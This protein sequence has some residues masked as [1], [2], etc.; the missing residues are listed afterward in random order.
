VR[1]A[2]LGTGSAF[3][4]ERYNG[5]VVVD[6]RL[7]L[8]AGA[9]LLPHMA[10]LGIDPGGIEALFLT[11]LH[12][13][14]IL[15]L[16]PY[17]LHRVFLGASGP[18]RV[19]GAKGVEEH[20]EKLFELSWH[21]EWAHFRERARLEYDE[22][23]QQGEV[24]GVAYET[25]GLKHGETPA[26]GYRLRV[27]GRLLAYAGDTQATSELEELV[28]GADVAITE[29]TNPGSAGVHTSWEQAQELAA[30]HPRTR[31]F[32]NHVFEG[33]PRGAVQDLEVVEV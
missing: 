22:G 26:R 17:L 20:L 29:A 5:A 33:D 31:F 15:G 24:A 21:G 9:P 8:D 19:V 6:N 30:R 7:L 14:H 13:D 18:F 4:T 32:F 16:P 2:F 12:G 23:R 10:R 11:H 1:L 25:V 27:E 28:R 3:S